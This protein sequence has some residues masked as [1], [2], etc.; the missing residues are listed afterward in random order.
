[1]PYGK[2]TVN[3]DDIEA[4]SK[5]ISAPLITTG[6]KTKEFEKSLCDYCGAKYAVAVSNGT[7]ALH[8]ASLALLKKGDE[9]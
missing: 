6:P 4:V 3:S 2:Q 7:A 1:M 9:V 5:A 8:L